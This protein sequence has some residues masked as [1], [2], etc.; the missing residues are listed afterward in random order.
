MQLRMKKLLAGTAV[1]LMLCGGAA[2]P[3]IAQHG[4][5]LIRIVDRSEADIIGRLIDIRGSLAVVQLPNG[6]LRYI[7]LTHAEKLVYDDLL[8][9]EVGIITPGAAVARMGG[10]ESEGFTEN[11]GWTPAPRRTVTQRN[12][13][14]QQR[15]TTP[16][17]RAQPTAAPSRPIRALW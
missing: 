13:N 5:E 9:S 17:R 3:A 4:G 8:G 15:S 10:L 11:V 14:V 6:D 2:L 1:A 7:H 12:F 16:V